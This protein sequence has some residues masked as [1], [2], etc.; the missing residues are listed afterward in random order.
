[1]AKELR[2]TPQLFDFLRELKVN[3]KKEWFDPNK[4]HYIE[5][6]RDPMLAFIAA[7]GSRLRDI[8]P[9]LV[10]DPKRS[11]FRIYRD[12]RFSKNKDPYKTQASCFFFHQTSGKEGLGIYVHLEPDS[13]FTG[14]GSWHPD[15]VKRTKITNSIANK[16]DAWREAVSGKE[17]RKMFKMEGESMA[18][19]PKQY[20]PQHP[21]ADDLKRKDFIAVLYLSEKQACA[22]DF[23][24]RID[25]ASHVA[26][27]YLEFL[28]KAI[29][30]KW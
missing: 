21:F 15:P 8:S 20:D 19:L 30:L 14:I 29:G 28:V 7:V 6:V 16:T 26:A 17:F 11:M 23:I 9:Y 2:F 1:M 22:K 3:N 12:I 4:P 13:C 24:D 5:Y 10:A 27:P 25:H 18:K